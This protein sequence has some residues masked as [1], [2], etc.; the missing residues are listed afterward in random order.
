M[1]YYKFCLFLVAWYPLSAWIGR[2]FLLLLILLRG[3][4]LLCVCN[5][6]PGYTVPAT[7]M[8]V[9]QSLGC[10]TRMQVAAL[11]LCGHTLPAA[12]FKVGSLLSLFI[13]SGVT[14]LTSNNRRRIVLSAT[15]VMT[16]ILC[17][18]IQEI[19]RYEK[20]NRTVWEFFLKNGCLI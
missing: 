20:K 15:N 17:S 4:L 12:G 5:L 8:P 6:R 19:E 7:C 11:A 14:M 10:W 2:P 1:L 3:M 18:H 16:G 13:G 9:G